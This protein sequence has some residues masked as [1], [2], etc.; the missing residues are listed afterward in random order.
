MNIQNQKKYLVK[1]YKKP[2]YMSIE[3]GIVGG[4]AFSFG[5]VTAL[6]SHEALSFWGGIWC[7]TNSLAILFAF[8]DTTLAAAKHRMVCTSIGCFMGL[9]ISFI[10]GANYLAIFLA[11]TLTVFFS[12]IFGI[13]KGSRIS[14]CVVVGIIGIKILA[15]N[16]EIWKNTLLRFTESAFG[17]GLALFA[18]YVGYV[19]SI[20]EYTKPKKPGCK[21]PG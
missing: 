11:V 6:Y 9:L 15:P 13:E 12:Q 20:R 1:Q 16:S 21:Q 17:I 10:F 8:M 14:S 18:A 19:I 2:V 4:L 7:M 3:A 5:Y